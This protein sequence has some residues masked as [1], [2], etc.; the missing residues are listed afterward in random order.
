MIPAGNKAKHLSS[1]N[2]TTKTFHHHHH[3]RHHHKTSIFEYLPS[4][5][6]VKNVSKCIF[7]LWSRTVENHQAVFKDARLRMTPNTEL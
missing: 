6:E 5:S 4:F 1:V 7:I 2:H 3:H